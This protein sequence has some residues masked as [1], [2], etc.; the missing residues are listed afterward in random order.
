MPH[1]ENPWLNLSSACALTTKPQF[2]S[3][4][5]CCEFWLN[6]LVCICC[7]QSWSVSRPRR[8]LSWLR[9]ALRGP[10]WEEPPANGWALLLDSSILSHCYRLH[11]TNMNSRFTWTCTFW[12]VNILK[13]IKELM[14]Y[15]NKCLY[16]S[17]LTHFLLKQPRKAYCFLRCLPLY[18]SR[19]VLWVS[20]VWTCT[21]V[22]VLCTLKWASMSV[23]WISS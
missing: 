14:K 11:C 6:V 5:P 12:S 15:V 9:R 7:R 19:A 8:S 21:S 4:I 22:W 13:R 1:F 23:P 2:Q 18:L 16:F 3:K 10:G 20:A 17:V